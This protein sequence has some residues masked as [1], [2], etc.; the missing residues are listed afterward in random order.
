M[1]ASR[2]DAFRAGAGLAALAVGVAG[3]ND[4]LAAKYGKV[5]YGSPE[6]LDPAQGELDRD[7]MKTAEFQKALENIKGYLAAVKDLEAKL[8][9]DN[10]LNVSPILSKNL[11][12]SKLRVNLNAVN[13]A[14]DE[15]TQRGTDRLIRA[16]IQ[17][18][19]ELDQAG[20]TKP[21]IPRSER[22]LNA[23]RGKL[24]KLEAA[25]TDF[26]KFFE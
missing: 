20:V 10:Q 18:I 19:T 2:R 17:D 15:D 5:G 23:M 22:K 14:L 13:A 25:F 26:L 8:E 4:A 12:F 7:V 16:T 1:S 21:G 11:E 9:A 6:V 24:N 3:P